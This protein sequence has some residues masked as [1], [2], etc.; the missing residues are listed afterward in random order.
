MPLRRCSAGWL[1]GRTPY[2][3]GNAVCERANAR[4]AL[5]RLISRLQL[6]GVASSEE[7]LEKRKKKGEKTCLR[8]S[9]AMPRLAA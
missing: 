5:Q 6:R 3:A 9:L 1:G 8:R 2:A 4:R 7:G